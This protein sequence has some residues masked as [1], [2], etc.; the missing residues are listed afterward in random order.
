[1]LGS[2][3]GIGGGK[4]LPVARFVVQLRVANVW[5]Q[6]LVLSKTSI[7]VR[8]TAQ[9]VYRATKSVLLE[10]PGLYDHRR[11]ERNKLLYRHKEIYWWAVRVDVCS[12][13]DVNRRVWVGF[14][15]IIGITRS[16]F[17]VEACSEVIEV[18]ER[19]VGRAHSTSG[20]Q[21]GLAYWCGAIDHALWG[22]REQVRCF[23][24]LDH[25]TQTVWVA[26][27]D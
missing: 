1:M 3:F 15:A 27:G 5:W 21:G 10:R 19:G 9:L 13:L 26:A 16:G 17:I 25:Q 18:A 23:E 6:S 24:L 11:T 22:L 12:S 20:V 4:T 8:A 2:Y 14:E 7:T